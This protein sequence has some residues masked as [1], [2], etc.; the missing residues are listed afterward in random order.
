[1]AHYISLFIILL[2]LHMVSPNSPNSNRIVDLLQSEGI[3]QKKTKKSHQEL[4]Q[5]LGKEANCN[6]CLGCFL[7]L[8]S[9]IVCPA[10]CAWWSGAFGLLGEGAISW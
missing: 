6:P 5:I 9:Y 1:M 10:D 2:R 3:F 4:L 7:P 8:G